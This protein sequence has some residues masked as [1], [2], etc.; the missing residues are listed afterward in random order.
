MKEGDGV[1]AVTLSEQGKREALQI[2]SSVGDKQEVTQ[3][4]RVDMRE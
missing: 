2:D 1:Y 4:R 3:P